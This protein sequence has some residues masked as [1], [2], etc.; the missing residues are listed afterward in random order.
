MIAAPDEAREAD[1][2]FY[3]HRESFDLTKRCFAE[4][5]ADPLWDELRCMW[6]EDRAPEICYR[7]CGVPEESSVANLDDVR[8]GDRI[9]LH[10]KPDRADVY[11]GRRSSHLRLPRDSG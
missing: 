7:Y 8:R 3:Q 5:A 9:A 11:P 2:W 4:V 10:L 1:L 6:A